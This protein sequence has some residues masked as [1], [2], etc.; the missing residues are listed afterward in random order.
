M[1]YWK[2]GNEEITEAD[3]RHNIAQAADLIQTYRPK[4]FLAD[5]SN[6]QF[7]Y[8]ARIQKWVAQT[9]ASACLSIGLKKYALIFPHGLMAKLSTELTV[10]AAGVIPSSTLIKYFDN[11][12]DALDWFKQ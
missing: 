10:D 11:R 9:L 8:E 1:S 7:I 5:D 3:I 4:Y 12:Q 2:E 6:R